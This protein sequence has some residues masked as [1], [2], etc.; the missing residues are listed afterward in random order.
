VA[1]PD[2]GTRGRGPLGSR[3]NRANPDPGT[4]N[5]QRSLAP[6][7]R[8]AALD[9][10]AELRQEKREKYLLLART[11]SY[12]MQARSTK[13]SVVAW[14]HGVEGWLRDKAGMQPQKDKPAR[15]QSYLGGKF[16]RMYLDGAVD[17][18]VIGE[19]GAEIGAS[20]EFKEL[21]AALQKKL[22]G[23]ITSNHLKTMAPDRILVAA[24][25]YLDTRRNRS[26]VAFRNTLNTVIG[27]VTD[28]DVAEVA[29]L[30]ES[31]G[32]HGVDRRYR[33]GLVFYD[34]YDFDNK[35]T[36]EYEAYRKK[37]ARLLQ[38]DRFDDFERAFGV[39]TGVYDGPR[40][41]SLDDAAVFASF[42]Y[43]LEKKRWTPGGLAWNVTVP[44]E[45]GLTF[46]KP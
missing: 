19:A 32:A 14:G 41:T 4:R 34:V 22:Q 28:T 29:L 5:Q 23:Q 40:K 24:D 21:V 9:K 35:R 27:G 45:I 17:A 10:L 3:T 44:C 36:G 42:M 15:V 6:K 16:L 26:G 37:L 13:Q 18:E 39:E 2:L 20:I 33:V 11:A 1:G 43:A 31:A 12:A 30:S 8:Q 38:A 7:D 46:A 25:K